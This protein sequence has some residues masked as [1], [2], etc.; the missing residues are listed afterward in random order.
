[1]DRR[2]FILASGSYGA[3]FALPAL[4]AG[5]GWG[6]THR[7][8]GLQLFTVMVPLEADFEGTLKRVADIGYREVETIGT[9]GR[10]PKYVRDQLDKYGLVSPSQHL[11]PGNLYDV[12]LRFTRKQISYDEI[13]ALWLKEMSIDKVVPTIEEGI[14]RAKVMGQQYLVWQILWPEQMQTL[15]AINAFC[16]ALDTAGSLC[17]KAGLTL[18]FHN[19]SDEFK[20]R[21]GFVPYQVI[22]D[23][24]DPRHVKLELDVFWAIRAG[25]NPVE[26][27]TRYSSRYVQ[28]H[29][30][31]ATA[32]GDFATVGKG[33]IDFPPIL[34]AARAAGIKH[35]YVEYDRSDDPMAVIRQA[36]AYLNP[37]M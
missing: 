32:S 5:R 23:K 27:L 6:A 30:K 19:H 8:L 16:R 26:L 2:Q 17:A 13:H 31:D 37:L 24:T 12:F 11:V 14:S 29:L 1:M 20:P 33:V 28:L 36:F 4:F 3:A 22:L 9:F 34:R 25:R 18:N 10:D 21:E 15:P 35:Y 7:P